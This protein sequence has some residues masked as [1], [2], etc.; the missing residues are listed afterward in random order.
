MGH[1]AGILIGSSRDHPGVTTGYSLGIHG[2][3]FGPR[4]NLTLMENVSHIFHEI[5][6]LN[7]LFKLRR[8][9]YLTRFYSLSIIDDK[10][11]F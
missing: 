6:R 8:E 9:E 10:L 1:S 3:P 5:V 7:I 4:A 2:I 11:I